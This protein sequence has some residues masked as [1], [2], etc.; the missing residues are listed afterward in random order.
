LF[1]P[2]RRKIEKREFDKKLKKKRVAEFQPHSELK[3]V[4]EERRCGKNID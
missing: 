4:G 1:D 3:A 2:Q